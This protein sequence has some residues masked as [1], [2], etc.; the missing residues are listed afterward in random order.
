MIYFLKLFINLHWGAFVSGRGKTRLFFIRVCPAESFERPSTDALFTLIRW[1][2]WTYG[3][4]RRRK[5]DQTATRNTGPIVNSSE[6]L[7]LDSSPRAG[8]EQGGPTARLLRRI[9]IGRI[10]SSRGT[11]S[12]ALHSLSAHLSPSRSLSATAPGCSMHQTNCIFAG[13][14]S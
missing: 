13:S 4:S 6:T 8:F 3:E 10:T 14:N 11:V 12:R 2:R 1:Y 9:P 5:K 7:S